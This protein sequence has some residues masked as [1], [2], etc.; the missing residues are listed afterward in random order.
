M[1]SVDEIIY[2]AIC[3]D[4]ALMEAIG[5]RVVSTCFEH[6]YLYWWN[7]WNGDC[8]QGNK[9]RELAYSD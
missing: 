1:K 5:S 4:T 6:A 7:A 9:G 8:E 2:D 3:A